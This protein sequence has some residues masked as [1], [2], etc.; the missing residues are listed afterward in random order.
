MKI[1]I[2]FIVTLVCGV[3]NRVAASAS[4]IVQLKNLFIA[5][6][7]EENREISSSLLTD[8]I[9]ESIN[10]KIEGFLDV[11]D[12][13]SKRSRRSNN[14]LVLNEKSESNRNLKT[15]IAPRGSVKPE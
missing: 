12:A 15:F 4:D 9:A 10:L 2:C 1:L 8:D 3:N 11:I 5:N 14:D 6:L 13:P 7:L